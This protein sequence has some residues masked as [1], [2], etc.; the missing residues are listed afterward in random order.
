MPKLRATLWI[1]TADH[2]EGLG[3][4]GYAGHA[5]RVYQEQVRV[6]LV[7]HA[8]DGSLGPRRIGALVRHVDLF[9]TLAEVVGARLSA[10]ENLLQGVSLGPLLRGEQVWTPRPAFAQRGRP[11]EGEGDLFAWRSGRYK[12]IYDEGG[13]DEL[14]DLIADPLETQ[15]LAAH[16]AAEREN[17]RAELLQQLALYRRH[18]RPSL[19]DERLDLEWIEELKALGYV[20]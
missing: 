13:T 19:S 16:A 5:E 6:P 1:V 20:R 4:H 2:G 9:P 12:Y 7:V 8:S 14:Y 11:L 17:L 3:S 15:N 10:E 18:Q